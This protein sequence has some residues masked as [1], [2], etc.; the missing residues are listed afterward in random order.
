[1]P[2]DTTTSRILRLLSL[3]QTRRFWTGQE[4]ADR[5]GVSGRTLRRDVERLR[6]LGYQLNT[7]R[8]TA[9]GYQLAAGAALPPLVLSDDEAVALAVSLRIAATSGPLVGL[10]ETGIAV[11]AKVE[12]VL[13]TRLQTR[14]RALRSTTVTSALQGDVVSA[15][16]ET[17]AR[18]ALA[19]LNTYRVGL[20]YRIDT[21]EISTMT[22]EPIALVPHAHRW[23][24][25]GWDLNGKEW[26][27]LRIDRIENVEETGLKF[28][29]REPP[30]ADVASYV[31]RLFGEF[32]Q[33][34]ANVIIEAP[35]EI[36]SAYLGHYV[37]DLSADGPARTHWH[38]QAERMETLAGGLAWLPW[39]FRI[40]SSPEFIQ[41]IRGL[42][43][44]MI[45]ATPP[46]PPA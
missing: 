25:V 7:V 43:L 14:V 24:L 38:I 46:R 9:G 31:A 8:G 22:V 13:P 42:G 10:A 35:Y 5:L 37:R 19:S 33:Y 15:D 4:L 39:D 3:F 40:E 20:R 36:T 45:H 12:Q 34:E 11:L 17:L 6:E 28:T 44:R 27:T 23:F 29:S 1:M 2:V 41:Y 16:P 32:P 26:R 30:D 18:L 21:G